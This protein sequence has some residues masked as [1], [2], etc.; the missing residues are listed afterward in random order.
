MLS[1]STTGEVHAASETAARL[2]SVIEALCRLPSADLQGLARALNASAIDATPVEVRGQVIGWRGRLGWS[3]GHEIRLEYIAPQGAL[4]RLSAEHWEASRPQMMAVAGPECRIRAGRRLLYEEGR[5]RAVALEQLDPELRPTGVR[6]PLDPV[7]PP[8][9]DP[10]GVLVALVDAGVNYLLPEVG[11]RLAR[12]SSGDILG[13]DYWDQDPRPF[14][15]NPARSPFFPQ[16]HGTRTATLLLSEAPGARLVPYRYP[17]PDMSRMA[18]LVSDAARKGVRIVNLSLGSNRLEDWQVFARAAKQHPEMLFIASAGNDG[19][20]IDAR[21][22]YPAA[23]GLA[24][25]LTAT[26]AEAT[27]T[28]GQGSNWG[29]RSVHVVVPAERLQVTDFDGKTRSVSG[30]SY[31][32]VRVTALAA[33]LLAQNPHWRALELK[34]AIL[35]RALRLPGEEGLYASAGFIPDPAK[36]EARMLEP[37]PAELGRRAHQVLTEEALYG[38]QGRLSEARYAFMPTFAYFP[39]TRW[40]QD[41][42]QAMAREVVTILGRCGVHVPRIELHLLDGPE[43]FRYFQQAV[44]EELVRRLS[45]PKPTVYF[46]RDTLQRVPFEAEA[47]GKGNSATRPDLVHTVWVTEGIR[48]PGVSLAHE[49]VHLLMDS[50]EHVDLPRNLMRADSSPENVELTDAQ[51]E[52]ILSRGVENGLLKPL[53]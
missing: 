15:A 38:A 21:P 34:N 20:D 24:N 28:L 13:Y 45:L 32:A 53:S 26:S 23:L 14:D 9:K 51:C 48:D 52:R 12:D 44:A 1:S 31:A 42:L 19:R 41:M 3:E 35:G 36:A 4:R 6:E 16:R 18:D 37:R 25:L 39:G 50:G 29:R 33:R 22:V 47:I 8:G 2:R 11:E 5:P 10:G 43:I 40:D 30:S 49:I 27:G 17:R 46:V 7:V